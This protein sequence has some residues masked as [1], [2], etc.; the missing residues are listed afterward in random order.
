[1]DDS[2]PGPSHGFADENLDVSDEDD[3]IQQLVDQASEDGDSN[4]DSDSEY[5]VP[6]PT[7]SISTS[8]MR[9][10]EFTKDDAIL[11]PIPGNGTPIDF[12][13]L[14]VDDVLLERI[15]KY[16]NDYAVNVVLLSNKNIEPKSRINAWRNLTIPELK[17]FLGLL[18]H[19]GTIR[20]NRLQDYWKKDWLFNIQCFGLVMPRDRFQI[21]LRCLHFSTCNPD[22][23]KNDTL[24][25]IS[26]M[27]DYFNNK[28]SSVYYPQKEMSLDEAMV[29][30]RGRLRFRQYIKNKRHKYGV[31][32]YTLTEHQ[33]F[34]LKFLIYAGSEDKIVGGVGHTE[35][36]VLCLLNRY[37]GKGH[38]VYMDNFYNSYNLASKLLANKTY[39]TGTLRVDRKYNPTEIKSAQ[40]KEGETIA[41]YS[42]GVM[43]GKWRDKRTVAYL[44]TEHEN[45]MVEFIDKRGQSKMKPLPIIKYNAHMSGVDRAD[46]MMSYYPCERKSVRWYKKIFIHI[47]QMI[48]LNSFHLYN[49]Y[50]DKITFYEFRLQ[51]IRSLLPRPEAIDSP[52]R[53]RLR[54]APEHKLTKST[55]RDRSNRLVRK[56]CRICTINKKQ[57]LTPYYCDDCPG[58]PGL[59]ADKCFTAYHDARP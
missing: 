45:N 30:W 16:T 59:C 18:F 50:K 6:I 2:V 20:L 48:L 51:V 15:C 29:L 17:I 31:K 53:K 52:G 26:M 32:L 46:Q 27:V 3:P 39:C 25:K 22:A 58:K 57:K 24:A 5:D 41:R 21:I 1:M 35:K 42:N 34:I 49:M 12:F 38:A 37:L 55:D 40:L 23:N 56:K 14:L 9:P 54:Q 11:L 33:G 28:M 44:S 47:M 43:V 10:I 8:G 36:V 4:S 19:T 7:W 13:N